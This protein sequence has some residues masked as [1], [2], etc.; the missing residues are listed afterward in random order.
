MK[1]SFVFPVLLL[2][3]VPVVARPPLRPPAPRSLRGHNASISTPLCPEQAADAIVAPKENVWHGLSHEENTAV[4]QWLFRQPELNLTIFEKADS[5]DNTIS[6]V[7]LMYPNKSDVVRYLDEHDEMPP[8]YA[9]VMLNNRASEDAYYQ[10]ILVG[11]LPIQPATGWTPLEF[12]MTR[13]TQGKVRNLNPDPALHQRWMFNVSAS[14]ADITWDLW[15]GTALGLDNDTL[16]LWGVDPMWQEKDGRVL[17]WDMY[18]NRPTSDDVDDAGSLLP[19]GLYLKSD[20]TGRD[21]TQWRVLG[22]LYNDIFYE[23]TEAF[24]AAY[25]TPGFVKLGA[26]VDGD[27]ALTHPQGPPLPRDDREPPA[28]VVPGGSRFGVDHKR[29][30]ISWMDFSFYVGFSRDTGLSLFD[31]RF[32]GQRILYELGLQEALA[33]YAGNDPVSSGTAFLD[34]FYGFGPYSFE[35]I[36]GHD[37]PAYAT[38]LNTTFHANDKTRTHINSLCLFEY[39]SDSAMRRHNSGSAVSSTRNVYLTLRSVATVGNYDYTFSYTFY[40][41]GTMGVEVKASGYVQA[42]FYAH[43]EEYGYRIRDALSGSMHDHV[44][45]FKADF[46]ILGTDNSVELTSMVPVTQSYVWS[47]RP[48][49]TMKLRRLLVG[50]EDEGRLFWE[51]GTQVH[52]INQDQRN[53]YGEFRGYH[54]LPAG[55]T[56][57]TVRNSS[58]LVHAARWAEYDVQITRQHDWEPR[59]AHAYNNQDVHDPPVDFSRFFDGE[60]LNQTD[61]VLWLNLGMHHVPHTG[62]LPNT[63]MTTAHAGLRFT[64]V[65]YLL[66]NPSRR[67][68]QAVRIQYGTNTETTVE[69][70]GPRPAQCAVKTPAQQLEQLWDY[71]GEV[72]ARKFPFN[73]NDP[74]H[75]T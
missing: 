46:D 20:V 31:V 64:P 6:W 29:Q 1:L 61:L 25:F 62:D 73:A 5:W 24:R 39:Q 23:T 75:H 44:M 4:V 65:N 70:F 16:V 40:L 56:H 26:N 12:P 63:V 19:L 21:P 9:R 11:P 41:D 14:I 3:G 13:K 27:W 33:H 43:N 7:E 53:R 55:T 59:G 52:V 2:G 8:R 57:L 36:K 34:S 68:R 58:T 45:S 71:Q 69:M 49:H 74:F 51:G 60:S 35:L 28:A 54:V 48:R 10:D 30:Y 72:V 67:T 50:S 66:D 22:W 47:E 42:A 38:Y 37:C 17:R 15:N 32:R 18:W